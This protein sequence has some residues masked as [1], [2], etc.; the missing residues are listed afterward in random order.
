MLSAFINVVEADRCREKMM[1]RMRAAR[2]AGAARLHDQKSGHKHSPARWSTAP[3]TLNCL[4][5]GEVIL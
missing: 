2:T 3:T 4:L 1:K 5:N